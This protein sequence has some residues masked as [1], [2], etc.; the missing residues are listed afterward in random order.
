[1]TFKHVLVA[2]DF[3]ECSD[4]A[5]K[6]GVEIAAGSA[7]TLTVVHAFELPYTYVSPFLSGEILS[8]ARAAAEH[9]LKK[10][11]EPIRTRIPAAAGVV[12]LGSPWEQILEAAR[13][14]GA[15]LIV[16]G[17]HGRAG[18]PRAL[19][20]SIAEKVVR[21]SAVPVLTVHGPPPT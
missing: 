20:G 8:E 11:L 12:R 19:L 13:E 10:V 6:Y 1:M 21:L 5:V 14:L 15:D 18:V 16:V 17:S 9:Q 4:A 2:T 7:S 3:S